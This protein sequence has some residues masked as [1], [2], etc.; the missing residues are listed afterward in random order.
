[1]SMTRT[2]H[3]A[4]SSK[5]GSSGKSGS[6]GM[7][8]GGFS[9]L[10]VARKVILTAALMTTLILVSLVGISLPQAG[11]L[12]IATGEAGF[13]TTTRLIANNAAGGLRWNKP[14]AIES[15]RSEEQTSELQ[16]RMRRSYA[17]L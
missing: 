11:K 4:Q 17:G 2:P 6:S 5:L 3:Q 10:S 12:A 8:L 15:A 7:S 1:M 16:S 9:R 14:D 13:S